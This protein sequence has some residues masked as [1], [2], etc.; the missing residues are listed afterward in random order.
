MKLYAIL[1]LSN[2]YHNKLYLDGRL[3]ASGNN[4]L[5]EIQLVPKGKRTLVQITLSNA[6]VILI[7]EYCPKPEQCDLRR[8]SSNACDG[9][10]NRDIKLNPQ[11]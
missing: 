11:Q 10:P 4:G 1:N 9:C 7:S 2:R 3:L 5:E 8:I 6:D